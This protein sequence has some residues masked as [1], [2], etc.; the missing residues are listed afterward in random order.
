M[1]DPLH[2]VINGGTTDKDN[3]NIYTNDDNKDAATK[4]SS[5]SPTIEKHDEMKPEYSEESEEEGKVSDIDQECT[6]FSGVTYLGAAQI[7]A[8]KSETEIQRNMA[9]LNEQHQHSE[10]GIKVSVSVPSFST[11]IVVLYDANTHSVIARYEIQSILFYARGVADTKEG[12]CFAFT[13]SHGETQESAIFQCHVFRCDIPE[14]VS[15]VSGCFSKAF[16]R[17]PRSMTNSVASVT[18][19]SSSACTLPDIQQR[20]LVCVFELSLEIK[21]DDGRGGFSSVY[22]DRSGF[23]LRS[24]LV[25]QIWISMKQVTDQAVSDG[26]HLHIERCFGILVAP[27]RHVKH[28]DMQLLEMVPMGT[29]T[30]NNTCES[31]VISGHWDP[32][33]AAFAPL[34]TETPKEITQY[35]TIAADLVIRGVPEPVRFLVE[36]PVKVFSQNERFWYFTKR[37]LVQQFILNLKEVLSPD[38]GDIIYEVSNLESTGDLDRNRLSLMLNISSLIRTPSITSID[39]LTPKEEYHSDGDEPLL[40]GTGWVSKDCPE[41]VLDSWAE[42]LSRWEPGEARPRGL[43]GLV[44]MGI[45]E[46][47]RGE[48]WLRLANADHDQQMMETYRILITK[49]SGCENVIQRDINRTF[50]AHDFFREAGGLGQDS[51]YK[52]S[53]AYA[54]YDQEVGY[55]Q[56]LSFL[57]ATLLLHMP[58]EQAFCVLVKLMYDYG[59][60]DLYK[61]GFENLYLRLHQL[62]RLIQEQLPPLGQH[63]AEHNIET[64]MFASQWFLTLFTARFPLYFVFHIIDVVLLQGI[65]TLFQVALALLTMCKKDLLQLD[66]EGI[67]KYFRVSLPRRCLTEEVS[68]G[69]MKLACSIKVKKLKKY[70][71]ELIDH[72]ES[73]ENAE[74][75]SNELARLKMAALK[76]EEQKQLLIEENSKLRVAIKDL[77][78]RHELETSRNAA[79]IAEYKQIC[80]RLDEQ[81]TQSKIALNEIREKVSGC[82]KCRVAMSNV[83]TSPAGQI[84]S[85]DHPLAPKHLKQQQQLNEEQAQVYER[86]HELELELAQAKLA[87]VEAECRNQALTHKLNATITELQTARNSWPPWLSKT[88]SSIKEVTNKKDIPTL[89]SFNHQTSQQQQNN[90]TSVAFTAHMGLLRRESA[91]H[92]QEILSNNDISRRESAP[93]IKDSQSYNSFRTM[94]N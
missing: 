8:P 87:Q 17:A 36:T 71:Q 5:G 3:Q 11:G 12:S 6:I 52:I 16:Q 30:T 69:V 56:G 34:N 44:K 73:Q 41:A 92:K 60:R 80:K 1:E 28:S 64:H 20:T 68:R 15:Q 33:D 24:K 58:E 54:V 39:T 2:N 78:S 46:A 32:S 83:P 77:T 31:Y 42:V 81:S 27:G 67:L 72:K 53:K 62:T 88:L 25:K 82:E 29:T 75:Y 90:P 89:N 43:A 26:P 86:V 35:I 51:L 37:P 45:P 9:I 47:L 63:F 84:S 85:G 66:F 38:T 93:I 74:N 70:E 50:P 14:A 40:S 79:I 94:N 59:L 13:W 23:K 91:P 7:N 4:S 19:M 55:C 76:H 18:D 10:Q 22:K 57:A 48:V 49:E 61:D 21:E 65:E